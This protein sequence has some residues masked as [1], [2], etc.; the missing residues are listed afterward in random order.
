V[1]QSRFGGLIAGLVCIA[2][3]VYL[4]QTQAQDENSL[5]EVIMHG[6]GIYFIGKGI[7]VWLSL[8]A[9]TEMARSLRAIERRPG[10]ADKARLEP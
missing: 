7:F 1:L 9:Q 5:I 3:G 4:L 8:N 10:P 6:M 2:A